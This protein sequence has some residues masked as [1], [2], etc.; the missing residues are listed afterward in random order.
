M[1]PAEVQKQLAIDQHS[2]QADEFAERYRDLHA[3]LYRSCF[4]YSRY[5]LDRW[6]EHFL[7]QR[8]EG[9]R[10]LDIGC[11]TGHYMARLRQRGF[12][13]AGVDG[14]EEMLEHA[15]AN[16]PGAEIARADVESVPFPDASF[17][18]VLCIEVLRYLPDARRCVQEMARL[19]KPGGVCLATAAPALNLNG[20]WIINRI[21]SSMRV[22]NLVRLKQFFTTSR[23]LRREFIAADFLTP[24]V[25]GVYFGPVNW[26][27]RLAPARLPRVLKAWEPVDAALADRPLLREFANMFL[28]YAVRKG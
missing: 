10:L 5:R 20:Y 11:G 15:R 22:S 12:A 13:V 3:D 16:N 7:P 18:F 23:R 8:G 24:T 17:D 9:L 4:T 25:H 6:L 14:S 26:V 2:V 28:V 1:E 19:L 27:E 21:A